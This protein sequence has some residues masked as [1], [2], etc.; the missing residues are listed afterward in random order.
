MSVLFC[1]ACPR[2]RRWSGTQ[3]VLNGHLLH[4]FLS[5]RK[6]NKEKNKVNIIIKIISKRKWS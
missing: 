4:D 3:W 2:L 5:K 6:K 1:A